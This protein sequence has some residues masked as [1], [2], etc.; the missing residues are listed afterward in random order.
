MALF[1]RSCRRISTGC[2]R[3]EFR[4][5]LFLSR[6]GSRTGASNMMLA[7]P[8]REIDPRECEVALLI[9][10]EFVSQPAQQNRDPSSFRCI[11]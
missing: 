11:S 6:G 1:S 2:S 5:I 8:V 4:W 10:T 3:G 7:V 9:K